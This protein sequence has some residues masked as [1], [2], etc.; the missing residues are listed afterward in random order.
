MHEILVAIITGAF[1]IIGIIIANIINAKRINKDIANK[2]DKQQAIFD[3]KLENLTR[4]VQVHNNFAER[5]PKLEAEI[6]S[7]K[8]FI[9]TK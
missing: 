9:Q 3:V 7:I 5:I 2:L 1:G 6:E 4:E 8:D